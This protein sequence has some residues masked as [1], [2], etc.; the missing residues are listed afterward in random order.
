MKNLSNM[1]IRLIHRHLLNCLLPVV[2]L[3]ASLAVP[4]TALAEGAEQKM[5]QEYFVQQA[6]SEDLL[7]TINAFEAEFESRVSGPNG[8]LLLQSGITGSRIVPVFQYIYAP[9]NNRQIDIEVTSSEHTAR[10]KF[11]IELTRL[12][13]WDSRSSSVSQAYR[14]LSFAT[15]MD[16][17]DSQASWTVK[18]DSLTNAGRLFQQYGM[19]EMRLWANYM[20]AHLVLFHLHDH[21][22][23]Y[24]MTNEILSELKGMRAQK[25]ELATLQLRSLALIGLRKSGVLNVS[26]GDP[27]PVQSVLSRIAELAR[28]MGYD[29]EQARA[30]YASGVEY[31]DQSA[32]KD[33]LEQFQLAVQIA[34]AVGSTEMAKAIRESIVQVHTAQGDAPATSEVLQEIESQ[35]VEDG[36][37][38]DLA[39]NLLAQARLLIG[40]YHYHRAL[41]VL[42]GALSYENNS[43][44]RRQ[45][46]FELAKILYETG[47]FD[48]SLTYLKLADITSDSSRKIRG[49]PVIDIGDGLRMLANIQRYKGEFDRMQTSRAAQGDYRPAADQYLYEQG[50]DAAARTGRNRQQSASFFRQSFEAAKAAGHTDLKQ[51]AYLQ[52][53]LT[54]NVTD[55]VC[56]K[57]GLNSAYE[58]LL[59][60]GVPRFSAEAMYV[61]AQLLVRDGQRREAL[62]VMDRLIDEIHMLRDSLPGVLGAWYWERHEQV[63]ESWLGMLVTESRQ[64]GSADGPASLLALSKMRYIEGA[65]Q[66][67]AG[68]GGGS[69][70]SDPLR[71]LLSQRSDPGAG[72]AVFALGEKINRELDSLRAGSR[73]KF[74]FL[75]DAGL[76]KYLRGLDHEESVLTFHLGPD[77]AQ[78]WVGRKDGIQRRALANPA[79]LYRKVQAA[80]QGLNNIGLAAFNNK[81]DALGKLLI[82]PVADLLTDTVYAIPAGPLLGF[83]L[84][85]LRLNGQYLLE[86]FNLVNLL[87]FP[88]NANP[89]NSLEVGSL[90]S[91][92]LAGN[93][94]DYAGDYATRLE[95]SAEISAVADLF[96]GPGLQIIQG[97]ALLPDEFQGGSFSQSNLVHLTM[98]GVINLK[99]PD[100][101]GLELSESEYEPGRVILMAP[102]IRSQSLGAGLVFLS[103]TK[104]TEKP[105]SGFNSQP[106]LVADFMSAG[107]RTVIVNF[108]AG[109]AESDT[110]FVT[111]F[112]QAL[113]ASGNIAG[114][115]RKSRLQYL[116]SSR[117]N[118][119]YDW[120][121]YQLYIR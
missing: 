112:Y 10:T 2:M 111:D 6:V 14:L 98:P 121:G 97:V 27:D 101:S 28:S 108:W 89:S 84:D 119:L 110:L 117:D 24:N 48:E 11:G 35:L 105:R 20:A 86:K 42:S 66:S 79:E 7:I 106:G 69:D 109:N 75:S 61:W 41:D 49:R 99:Y 45:I 83:P 33:A 23:V 25:L 17:A 67:A 43:A 59:A 22:I 76:E 120:A 5:S 56:T 4:A 113:K 96:V 29:Y 13:P 74:E 95:T 82:A 3:M 80:R 104:I 93:P 73:Q 21:S 52:Y 18:I 102:E 46:N 100:E 87:A 57:A 77:M 85:A 44:I 9:K 62:A 15:E 40:A 51:L 54:A 72:K 38:D 39:L 31:A 107:A 32:Y 26:A 70:A 53:C 103:S 37:G 30:L 19:Q 68:K 16:G 71:N 58:W 78:V 65:A 90:Q 92:F 94:Q 64:P 116:K 36:G 63:F 47:Y 1:E 60:S 118:G 81:M 88:Q 55:G 8:E 91:M 115:L 50:L 34:D 12:K 114:S